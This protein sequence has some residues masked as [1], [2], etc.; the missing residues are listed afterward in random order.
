VHNPLAVVDQSKAAR[1]SLTTRSKRAHHSLFRVIWHIESHLRHTTSAARYPGLAL[2]C[3]RAPFAK[4]L[5][6]ESVE[7]WLAD[8]YKP[9]PWS[10]TF[11]ISAM[12]H[13]RG[14]ASST[15]CK[16]SLMT[17]RIGIVA[18]TGEL[19]T[20]ADVYRSPAGRF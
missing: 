17:L 1:T 8:D 19:G 3:R 7:S 20:I 15:S 16:L 14:T 13:I 4:V 6:R 10:S 18:I 9:S 11:S 2:S 5:I 12:F